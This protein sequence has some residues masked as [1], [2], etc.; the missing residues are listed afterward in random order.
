MYMHSNMYTTH[1]K[2]QTK[3]ATEDSF[4]DTLSNIATNPLFK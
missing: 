4:C 3:Q 1:K 2:K